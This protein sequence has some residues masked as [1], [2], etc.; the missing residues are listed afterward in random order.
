MPKKPNI[1]VED[2]KSHSNR[3]WQRILDENITDI[4]LILSAMNAVN[5]ADKWAMNVNRR[6]LLG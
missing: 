5:N 4:W 6:D 2:V 1:K 3:Q